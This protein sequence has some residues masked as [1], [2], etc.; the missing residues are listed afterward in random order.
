MRKPS[1]RIKWETH[2]RHPEE[3]L[4]LGRPEIVD[5]FLLTAI[6]HLSGTESAGVSRKYDGAP[7][8]VFGID[9]ECRFFMATKH[10]HHAKRPVR[11][12]Y[13]DDVDKYL[14]P[15]L[16]LLFR[17][18]WT[19]LFRISME[20]LSAGEAVGA[21]VMHDHVP[22]QGRFMPNVCRYEY[23]Y[24]G[25]LPERSLPERGLAVHTEYKVGKC[26][27]QKPI[28]ARRI[29]RLE[30]DRS[31]MIIGGPLKPMNDPRAVRELILIRKKL[32]ELPHPVE[33]NPLAAELIRVENTILKDDSDDYTIA[34]RSHFRIRLEALQRD[35]MLDMDHHL[36]ELK[37]ERGREN[38]RRK[39]E[40][41]LRR[42]ESVSALRD[43]WKCVELVQRA[44]T[45]ILRA[46]GPD[47]LLDSRPDE[48]L[49][50]YLPSGE[51]LKVVERSIFSARN[52]SENVER[53][54][55]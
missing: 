32:S 47:A 26:P 40:E 9:T 1:T 17:R 25:S 45:V 20:A 54:W 23:R 39:Y 27:S 35:I 34:P 29:R 15:E 4:A 8:I 48:G 55:R 43:H 28:S 18:L 52:F 2:L 31:T 46:V 13:P 10:G 3:F 30:V 50:W 22:I 38:A 6:D 42:I 16:A 7:S 53:G 11:I 21:D 24:L 37:T 51:R 14:R 36:S 33:V 49:V 5:E 12:T 19:P 44:K 41:K